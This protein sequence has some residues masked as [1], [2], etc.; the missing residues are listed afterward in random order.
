MA[1]RPKHF[2]EGKTLELAIELFRAKGFDCTGISELEEALGLG[3]QSIYNTFGD[4]RS[5]F[6]K[7]FLHYSQN[8][9][10]SM[11]ALLQQE[12]SPKYKINH[13]F[14]T[15]IDDQCS[16]TQS[17][18]LLVNSLSSSM[19]S[20]PEVTKIINDSLKRL[21]KALSNCIKETIPDTKKRNNT[22]WLLVNTIQGLCLLSSSGQKKQ[23]L[24]D[25]KNTTI[26]LIF[27]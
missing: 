6:L 20:D 3:R 15:L 19:K 5:L 2:D 24:T 1:G 18:C 11:I 13:F 25:I 14:S 7:A 22:A 9:S 16:D 23:K 8:K 26:S 10:G 12:G 17:G 27:T 4:K 21:H